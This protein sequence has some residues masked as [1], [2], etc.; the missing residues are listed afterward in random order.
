MARKK[1]TNSNRQKALEVLRPHIEKKR[2]E[3]IQILM[4]ELGVSEGYA[5]TL[6]QY[7][8]EESKTGGDFKKVFSVQDRKEGKDVAP[9]LQSHF[10]PKVSKRDKVLAATEDEAVD[11]YVAN[12]QTKIT[13]AEGLK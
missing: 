8:R 9:Y 12:Q 3:K 11:K 13:A 2:A 4:D 6:Y 10:L 5:G 1:D 7:H